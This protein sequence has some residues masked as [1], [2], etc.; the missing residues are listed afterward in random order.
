M[1]LIKFENVNL[2]T[3]VAAVAGIYVIALIFKLIDDISKPKPQAYSIFAI[4]P[5]KKRRVFSETTK[6]TALFRQ[7][8]VCNMCKMPS[9]LWD[10]HHIDGVRSNNWP[11]NC[12]ALCPNCHAKKTRIKKA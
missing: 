10:Y 3:L 4:P 9:E 5:P 2:Q 7:G 8:F 11:S 1:Q 6:R 12:E